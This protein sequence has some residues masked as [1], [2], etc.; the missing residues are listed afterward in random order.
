M[1]KVYNPGSP[2]PINRAVLLRRDGAA[3]LKFN[4]VKIGSAS[5]SYSYYNNETNQHEISEISARLFQ[6]AGGKFIA[7]IEDY[8]RT[9]SQYDS[10]IALKADSLAELVEAIK[11][12]L[13]N[14]DLLAELF[15][16]TEIADSLAETVE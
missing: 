3:P 13:N 14:D 7:G 12:K 5:R 2:E 1:V 10:R 9:T 4:G 8:N 15:E 16:S 6:T 11:P